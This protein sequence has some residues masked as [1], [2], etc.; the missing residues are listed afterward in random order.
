MKAGRKMTS[1][2]RLEKLRKKKKRNNLIFKWIFWI[3][4]IVF[5]V[6]FYKVCEHVGKEN[7]GRQMDIYY[8]M[9]KN[10]P[11]KTNDCSCDN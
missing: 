10:D 1:E 7:L 11:P 4:I 6:G 9:H 8:E 5:V 3:I 2:I